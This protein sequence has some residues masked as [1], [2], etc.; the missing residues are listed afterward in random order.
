MA[1]LSR[2]HGRTTSGFRQVLMEDDAGTVGDE[3]LQ[4]AR[5]M[6]KGVDFYVCENRLTGI[7]N[8]VAARPETQLVILDDALQHRRL[9]GHLNILLTTWDKP[10]ATDHVVPAGTLRDIRGRAAYMDVVIVTKCPDDL[11]PDLATWQA[12]LGLQPHQRLFFSRYRYGEPIIVNGSSDGRL[13]HI[14]TDA[15]IVTLTGVAKGEDLHKHVCKSHPKATHMAF[16]DHHVFTPSDLERT[17]RKF[18]NFAPNDRWIV[19]T[20]K[21]HT[22]LERHLSFLKQRSVNVAYVPIDVEILERQ[23]ELIKLIRS[24]VD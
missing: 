1:V 15:S 11:D 22:R 5:R 20:E 14:P 6:A 3:P 12:K 19:T 13:Q 24:Y 23:E 17:L 16:P 21:D 9:S 18:A 4:M 2:G 10:Y 7:G 8:I